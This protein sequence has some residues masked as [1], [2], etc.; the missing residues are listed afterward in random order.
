[1]SDKIQKWIILPDMQVPFEDKKSLTAVEKYM[2]AHKWDGWLQLGDFLDF[3]A[4]SSFVKGKP[5]AVLANVAATFEAGRILLKRHA[6]I[7][8]TNNANARM[9]VIQGNHDYRAVSYAEEHPG[10]REHLDVPKNLGFNELDVEWIKSWEDGKLFKLGHAYFTHGLYITTHHAKKMVDA[11]GVCVYY[12]H[13]HS[14][15]FYAKQNKGD[16]KTLEG[17]SLG[18]LCAYAQKYLQGAPTAWQQAVS[19]LFLQ[20]NG[21]YNLYTSYIFNHKFIGPDGVEY[22]A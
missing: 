4:L 1:L 11:F 10:L 22:A 5:G 12:G 15:Q 9:V 14:I 17:G 3:D 19:T 20:P 13:T 21:N 18:C 16:N 2:A 8:R 6:K 7:I